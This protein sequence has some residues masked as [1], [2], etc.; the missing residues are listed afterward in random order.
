MKAYL[1]ARKLLYAIDNVSSKV[2]S[3]SSSSSELSSSSSSKLDV[4]IDKIK[5]YSILLIALR[6]QSA[7]MHK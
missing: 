2:D 6:K 4:E 5:V 1:Q 3:T 7:S